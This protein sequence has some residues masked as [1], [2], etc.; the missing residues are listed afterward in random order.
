MF[1]KIHFGSWKKSQK[2]KLG[3]DNS[4][5]LFN[6]KEEEE[7]WILRRIFL[8]NELRVSFQ[9]KS[10]LAAEAK[11]FVKQLQHYY[12]LSLLHTLFLSF[13][14]THTQTHFLSLS[15]TLLLT[16]SHI[17]SLSHTHAHTH[18][19]TDTH[20][21]THTLFF[22]HLITHSLSLSLSLSISFLFL[23]NDILRKRNKAE[24]WLS[25]ISKVKL[26]P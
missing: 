18:R 11:R 24:T 23:H 12:S 10:V 15:I 20:T 9:D 25:R 3:F 2:T 5:M 22:T 14:Q 16:Y 21:Q 26:F 13:S 4:I 19:D 17:L 1:R 7:I 6:W 8:E